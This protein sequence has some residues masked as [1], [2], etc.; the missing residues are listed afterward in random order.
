MLIT[1]I[2]NR[3]IKIGIRCRRE[4]L[5]K[6]RLLFLVCNESRFISI[7]FFIESKTN[8]RIGALRCEKCYVGNCC[9]L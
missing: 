6:K 1:L 5:G 8:A 9:L 4:R 2:S 3:Q 7:E